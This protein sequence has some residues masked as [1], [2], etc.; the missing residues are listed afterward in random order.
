MDR[1]R[2]FVAVPVPDELRA[3]LRSRLDAWRAEPDAPDLRWTDPQGWHLTLAF[4]GSVD[5]D[6]LA[7]IE[8]A[9]ADAVARARPDRLSA[10]GLGAFPSPRRARVLWYGVADP[11]ASLRTLADGVRER[12]APLMPRL[13]DEAPFRGHVTVGRTR[14]Q[15]GSDLGPWLA[16]HAAPTGTVPLE[17][18]ILYRSHLGGRGPARYEALG[19]ATVGQTGWMRGTAGAEASVHE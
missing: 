8:Q 13:G 3:A 6:T 10:G 5:V 9:V 15:R 11:D 19:W 17:R 14:G 4:L 16:R 1:W 12:L 7:G 2:C 18:V